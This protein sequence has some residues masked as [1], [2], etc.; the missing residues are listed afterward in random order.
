MLTTLGGPQAAAAQRPSLGPL[1]FEEGYPL[2]RMGL[3]PQ[4]EIPDAVDQGRVRLDLWMGYSNVFERDSS[5]VHDVY[6]DLERFIWTATLRYGI[7]QDLEVGG[8]LTLEHTGGGFLDA[9]MVDFHDV[10]ALGSRARRRFP[11]GDYR[12]TVHDANGDLRVD[13][14]KR[15]LALEDVRV[16]AKWQAYESED[17]RSVVSLRTVARIPTATDQL[18]GERA[19]VSLLAMGRRPWRGWHV[20]G[21]LG[22][23]T[24]RSAP[25]LEDLMKDWSYLFY[26]GLERPF[27]DSL[28]GVIQYVESKHIFQP[29]G[30]S[31][32]DNA[33]A[34]I[35][36]GV[37]GKAGGGWE[38]QVS[39]QEDHPPRGPSLD[40]QFQ[41][42]LSKSW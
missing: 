4:L 13:I 10:L 27:S 16:F 2:Q 31:D 30:D 6:L 37:V 25:D 23:L 39:M 35:V 19:D 9:F 24:V 21:G 34:N 33:L 42:V 7:A 15:Y 28:S 11:Y 29:F 14:P 18:G 38:W 3:T 8:R 1:T 17:G 36:L 40:F 26:F 22:V 12:A 41:V 20:H 5:V 32:V